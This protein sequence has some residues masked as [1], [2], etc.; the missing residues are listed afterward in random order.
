LTICG[1]VPIK[2]A[3]V[4][5]YRMLLETMRNAGPPKREPSAPRKRAGDMRP[6]ANNRDAMSDLKRILAERKALYSKADI[7]VEASGHTFEESLEIL[8]Q[9]L[10]D[11]SVRESLT[12][13]VISR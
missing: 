4:R 6:M 3:E 5:P 13:A 9:A 7:Q 11:T 12:P 10:R 8:I 1:T 2:I